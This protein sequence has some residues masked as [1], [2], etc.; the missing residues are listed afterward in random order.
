M[1]WNE[2][3]TEEF[4]VRLEGTE[5]ASTAR[6]MDEQESGEEI[7]ETLRVAEN[8]MV[9]VLRWCPN[10]VEHEAEDV[11]RDVAVPWA[12]RL[13]KLAHALVN[14]VDWLALRDAEELEGIA[15]MARHEL[16]SLEHELDILDAGAVTWR[17]VDAC[18]RTQGRL[19][20]VCS[21]LHQTVCETQGIDRP[22]AW[23]ELELARS[24]RVRR[25]LSGLW[26]GVQQAAEVEDIAARLRRTA[27]AIAETVGA[28]SFGDVRIADRVLLQNLRSEVLHWL[29]G[30]RNER[31]AEYIWQDLQGFVELTRGINRRQ[32]L[33]DH[34]REAANA[35]ASALPDLEPEQPLPAAPWT[36]ARS[37][38]GGREEVDS[39][40]LEPK[41][42]SVAEWNPLLPLR[43]DSLAVP[44]AR[45]HQDSRPTVQLTVC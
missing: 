24:L 5:I 9:Q 25:I 45:Q 35:L 39:V 27:M 36:Q 11:A 30:D 42:P 43:R 3:I 6:C 26:S 17:I 13:L 38:Q 34:D 41:T 12:L 14:Q 2:E 33:I 18:A 28:P 29:S 37:L 40:V 16:R 10:A 15:A 23:E 44:T 7:A 19:S 20:R 1:D 31:D 32:E 4:N 21:S 22:R 8:L